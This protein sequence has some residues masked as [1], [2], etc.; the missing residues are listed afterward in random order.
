MKVVVPR[1]DQHLGSS[2]LPTPAADGQETTSA[3]SS[4]LGQDVSGEM[5]D[6]MNGTIRGRAPHFQVARPC[7][8]PQQFTAPCA[9]R[10]RRQP[11]FAHAR[12]TQRNVASGLQRAG[13]RLSRERTVRA[14]AE[15]LIA[16]T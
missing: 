14:A 11:T 13:S 5:T 2:T 8:E 7:V 3:V 6:K 1:A 15:I 9:R 10:R 12:I 16:A 4:W